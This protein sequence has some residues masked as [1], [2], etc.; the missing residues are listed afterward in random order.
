MDYNTHIK[1]IAG[2]VI[3]VLEREPK[4]QDYDPFQDRDLVNQVMYG[5]AEQYAKDN[6]WRGAAKNRY[7]SD[8]ED[9]TFVTTQMICGASP[10]IELSFNGQYRKDLLRDVAWYALLNDVYL[11]VKKSYP[12]IYDPGFCNR[13]N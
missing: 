6:K 2:R 11:E 8:V 12:E 5:E 9:L 1:N 10:S 3:R 13:S 7:G 4:D